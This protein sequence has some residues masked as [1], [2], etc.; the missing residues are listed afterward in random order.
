[1][2]IV[3][4]ILAAGLCF[5]AWFNRRDKGVMVFLLAAAALD[6]W[7]FADMVA[8]NHQYAYN[9]QPQDAQEPVEPDPR[10]DRR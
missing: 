10:P 9:L 1:M 2:G 4:A 5:A 8:T 7:G 6:V 3:F